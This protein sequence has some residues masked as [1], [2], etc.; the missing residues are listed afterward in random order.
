MLLS[1]LAAS[2]SSLFV[3]ILV[4]LHFIKPELDP[5]WRMI[6]EYEIG[7][8]GWLMRLAFVV[9]GLGVLCL[10]LKLVE[11]FPTP[12]YLITGWLGVLTIALCGAAAFKTNP[13]LDNLKEGSGNIENT[14]H[15]IC[16]AIVIL[17]FPIIATIIAFNIGSILA[18]GRLPFLVVL[19]SLIWIGQIA[20]FASISL[21]QRNNPTAG[22]VG[23]TVFLGWPNRIMVVLYVIWIS[24]VALML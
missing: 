14:I 11:V 4:L 21:S 10:L 3:V 12:N 15:T 2:F 9:W 19:T 1:T 16:G 20:F 24:V 5:K 13:I 18:P 7:K 17:T 22:R 8:H 23:P 6:S